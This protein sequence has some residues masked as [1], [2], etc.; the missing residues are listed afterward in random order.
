MVIAIDGPAGTG[1]STVAR[2]IAR[3]AKLF[4]IN[5]GNFYRAVTWKVL[6][7][8]VSPDDQESIVRLARATDIT[9]SDGHIHIDGENHEKE[10]R[11]DR[12]DQWVAQHSAIPEVR[13]VVNDR[14]RAISHSLDV[15]VEGRDISTVVFP[16]ADV[17]IYLDADVQTRARR[18]FD[19]NTSTLSLQ[20]IEQRIAERDKRDRTKK[21]GA[22]KIAEDALYLDTSDLTIDQV[23]ETVIDTIRKT[24]KKSGVTGQS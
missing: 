4:Y 3:E 6:H 20:E 10:L 24:G 23:C 17:K 14:L 12:V 19:E 11:S 9:I 16:D 21:T 2:R 5:S 13:D 1:K 7:N 15:I 8:G 18:R 22:L